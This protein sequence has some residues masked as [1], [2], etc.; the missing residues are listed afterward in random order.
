MTR[1][2]RTLAILSIPA[3][4]ILF[5]ATLRFGL[6]IGNPVLVVPDAACGYILK[7]SQH[8]KRFGAH[9]DTN[10]LGMRSSDFSPAKDPHTLRIL[11]VGDSLT[12]GTSR[13]D[14]NDLFTQILRRE[15]P[16]KAGRPVE[17]LNASA[18]SWAVD[19]ELSYIQ[20]RGTFASDLVILVVNNDDLFQPRAT[21]QEFSETLLIHPYDTAT[22]ELIDRFVWPHLLGL[23]FPRPKPERIAAEPQALAMNLAEIAQMKDLAERG[24]SRFVLVFLPFRTDIPDVNAQAEDAFRSW[25][26]NHAVPFIDLTAAEST[27]SVSEISFD[28]GMHFNTRGNRVI[29]DALKQQWPDL[30]AVH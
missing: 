7:P 16:A 9:I 14:Q 22:G 3:L 13:V 20:S 27:H 11:F 30:S 23:A 12:Y 15:L 4:L 28:H 21:L 19:N 18:G 8:L 5:E 26:S 2:R 1:R 10:S 17:V 24:G 25:A 29:A 6:G